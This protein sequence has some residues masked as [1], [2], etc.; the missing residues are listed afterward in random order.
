M[1]MPNVDA[2]QEDL[3]MAQN[4]VTQTEL[5]YGKN[6]FEYQAALK[7]FSQLWFVLKMSRRQEEFC[8]D[9]TNKALTPVY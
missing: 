7:H 2:L 4:R 5:A 9:L 6:S 1:P 3:V 8:H